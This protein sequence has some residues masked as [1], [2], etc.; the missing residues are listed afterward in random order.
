MPL[1]KARNAV[2]C[3]GCGAEVHPLLFRYLFLS[4]GWRGKPTPHPHKTYH[5]TLC[6]PC[7]DVVLLSLTPLVPG[8]HE[9][10]T[11]VKS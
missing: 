6:G 9:L 8:L 10:P 2:K 5:L 11:G 3:D 7:A 4:A 1:P